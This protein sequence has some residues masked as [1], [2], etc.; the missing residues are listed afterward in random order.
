[1]PAAHEG[2][3]DHCAGSIRTSASSYPAQ[4]VESRLSD[5]LQRHFIKRMEN[6][7]RYRYVQEKVLSH[8]W[9]VLNLSDHGTET[10]Y[11]RTRRR[12]FAFRY[13]GITFLVWILSK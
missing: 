13:L 3:R 9:D 7:R 11:K 2:H 12:S 8:P 1:M 10:F 4:L 6:T 5:Y